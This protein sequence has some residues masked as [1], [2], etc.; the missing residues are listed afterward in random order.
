MQ[1]CSDGWS[2][3][4]CPQA[5]PNQVSRKSFLFSCEAPPPWPEF[6]A[7][8][9]LEPSQRLRGPV[10]S[11]H[12]A[13]GRD[14]QPAWRDSCSVVSGDGASELKVGGAGAGVSLIVGVA[15]RATPP[16][17]LSY[18]RRASSSAPHTLWV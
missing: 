11:G 6:P 16:A 18:L 13:H 3:V 7:L 4:I 17:S 5:G 8:L 10:E 2:V 12:L 14:A 15:L 1:A 9:S